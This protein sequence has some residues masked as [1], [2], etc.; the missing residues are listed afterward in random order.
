M[1]AVQEEAQLQHLVAVLRSTS[2]VKSVS[3]V[4]RDKNKLN[5]RRIM[6]D[7]EAPA[8]DEKG[9]SVIT[10]SANCKAEVPTLLA[11][12]RVAR[13]KVAEIIG[14][15]AIAAAEE[16]VAAR[17]PPS[18]STTTSA[19]L[20]VFEFQRER[21]RLLGGLEAA[22]LRVEKARA[23]E[24]CADVELERQLAEH[25]A[26]KAALEAHLQRHPSKRVREADCTWPARSA[27]G[28]LCQERQRSLGRGAEP[29]REG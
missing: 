28:A 1:G 10:V 20:P 5:A 3:I 2:G 18:S 29:R 15:A 8:N 12:A 9:R 22:R 26:A 6:C 23:A 14:E 16:R 4:G 25:N 17:T 13:G 24:R 19:G 27:Q 7:V 21:T 11:A